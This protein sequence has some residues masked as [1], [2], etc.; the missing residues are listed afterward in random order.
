[1]GILLSIKG[2][3]TA[4]GGVLGIWYGLAKVWFIKHQV[5]IAALIKLLEEQYSDGVWTTE[6]KIA[7]KDAAIKKL[8]LVGLPWYIPQWLALKV[9]NSF[10]DKV[11]QKAKDARADLQ[12]LV[13]TKVT[14]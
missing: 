9:I 7:W 2:I 6:E 1:M 14:N 5:D 3:T 12:N 10:V 4:V 8:I 13:P 11:M